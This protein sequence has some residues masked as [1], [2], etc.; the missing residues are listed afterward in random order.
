MKVVKADRIKVYR[1]RS[2]AHHP[3]GRNPV[4]HFFQMLRIVPSTNNKAINLMFLNA[5]WGASS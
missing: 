2:V 4:Q 3:D 5:Q 1:M